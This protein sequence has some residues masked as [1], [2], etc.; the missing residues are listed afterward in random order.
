[1]GSMLVF[2]IISEIPFDIGF[3]HAYSMEAGAFPFYFA[4]QNV[5]FFI[6]RIR[7]YFLHYFWDWYV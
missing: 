7:M 3:F 1:M 6:L 4:Y 5:F 2:A